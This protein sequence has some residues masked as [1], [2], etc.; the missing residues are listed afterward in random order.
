MS[1]ESLEVYAVDTR[2]HLNTGG[3]GDS[4]VPGLITQVRILGKDC[5]EYQVAYWKDCDHKTA[6]VSEA[7]FTPDVLGEKSQRTIGFKNGE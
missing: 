3:A 1:Y 6:W 7:E 2:V 5:V 4:A